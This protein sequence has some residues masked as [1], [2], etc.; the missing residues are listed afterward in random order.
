MNIP[1][2]HRLKVIIF[3][4]ETLSYFTQGFL[5]LASRI[6]YSLL[7]FGLVLYNFPGVH[8]T[9]LS[10]FASSLSIISCDIFFSAFQFV[11]LQK[12]CRYRRIYERQQPREIKL[13]ILSRSIAKRKS[14]IGLIS[15]AC[16][17]L[18]LLCI[19]ISLTLRSVVAY[20]E[21]CIAECYTLIWF[22]G[23][24]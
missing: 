4:T 14:M 9:I 6:C 18:L 23:K 22:H 21:N 15:C 16:I 19:L 11:L 1:L 2:L 13:N 12:I 24:L 5:H 10:M 3:C 20:F 17:S 8:T 7:L